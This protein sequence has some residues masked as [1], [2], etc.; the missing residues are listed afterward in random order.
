M[1]APD[2][3]LAAADGRLALADGQV[4]ASDG[5]Q[6]VAEVRERRLDGQ[7][8]ERSARPWRRD[9]RQDAASASARAADGRERAMDAGT[10]P[11]DAADAIR[12]ATIRQEAQSDGVCHVAKTARYQPLTNV[13]L[14]K[15]LRH[16][17]RTNG[18]GGVSQFSRSFGGFGS[19]PYESFDRIRP[20]RAWVT[21]STPSRRASVFPLVTAASCV[22]CVERVFPRW[23]TR[24]VRADESETWTSDLRTVLSS[25]PILAF[26]PPCLGSVSPAARMLEGDGLDPI[27]MNPC[28]SVSNACWY[29]PVTTS[30]PRDNATWEADQMKITPLSAGEKTGPF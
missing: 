18:S 10:R 13:L 9:T 17:A 1:A 22:R 23:L 3:R 2:V 15:S 25:D 11:A 7:R 24:Q 19:V 26:V 14:S 16:G 6:R 8:R 30:K 4:D 5:R 27:S 12:C 20:S 29:G 28:L 21:R